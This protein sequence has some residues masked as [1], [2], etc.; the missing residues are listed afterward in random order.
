LAREIPLSKIFEL[1][2]DLLK[3]LNASRKEFA[4]SAS[5]LLSDDLAAE[6]IVYVIT[7]Y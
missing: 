6:P 7:I 4:G 2:L 5:S 1:S 3:L